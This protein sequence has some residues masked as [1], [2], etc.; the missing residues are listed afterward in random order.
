MPRN[1]WSA[2]ADFSFL[3]FFVLRVK[4]LAAQETITMQCSGRVTTFSASGDV[5]G[6]GPQETV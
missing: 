1:G 2:F 5:R 3:L 6:D 4:C